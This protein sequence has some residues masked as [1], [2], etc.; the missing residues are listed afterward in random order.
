M[1]RFHSRTA[2]VE[3]LSAERGRPRITFQH[4]PEQYMFGCHNYGEIPSLRNRAD[5]DPWDVFAPGYGFHALSDQRP[6][7]VKDVIGYLRL[8][9]GNDKLAVLLYVPGFDEN[10]AKEE[11]SRFVRSYTRSVVK[12]YWVPLREEWKMDNGE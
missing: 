5:G 6:Y 1:S 7:R 2:V 10:D 8:K 3:R 12:G 11:I 9:N 4:R